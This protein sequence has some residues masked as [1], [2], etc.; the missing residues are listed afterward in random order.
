MEKTIEHPGIAI[1]RL[2]CICFV[3][4]EMGWA[5][6]VD[7]AENGLL[8]K[9]TD[10]GEN[11]AVSRI[12]VN[13][14]PMAIFFS[15]SETGWMGGATP[16]PGDDEGAGGPSVILGTTDGG[17][18]WQHQLNTP[19][20]IFDICFVDRA[21]GWASGTRGAIYHTDD[22]GRTWNSQRTELEVGEGPIS[23]SAK[24][25]SSLGLSACTLSTLNTGS[26]RLLRKKRTPGVFWRRATAERP[27]ADNGS[28]RTRSARRLLHQPERRMGGHRP[29]SVRLYNCRWR[30]HVA[31]RAKVFEQTLLASG[32]GCRRKTRVGGGRRR[33][34]LSSERVTRQSSTWSLCFSSQRWR[35]ARCCV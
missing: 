17:Q 31:V 25:R 23:M 2:N 28:L 13:Q 11:W 7:Q 30:A 19:V 9:T 16:A 3:S 10:G 24:A 32:S 14:I 12:G 35:E 1:P 6:G 34:V 33:G 8:L 22:G 29:G 21:H 4:P 15:D 27:G 5:V 18:T 20:S 26:P